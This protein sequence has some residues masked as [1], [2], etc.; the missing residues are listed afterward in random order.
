MTYAPEHEKELPDRPYRGRME[1][2]RAPRPGARGARTAEDPHHPRD[3][4][5]RLL[6]PQK[7]LPLA[8]TSARLPALA[9]RLLVVRKMARRRNPFE[10]LT[11]AL[12]ERLR[13]RLGRNPLPSAGIADSQS[14]KTTG[15]GGQQRGYDGGK[16]V[17][18]R[19]RHL[20]VDTEGLLLKARVHSAK[21]PDQDGLRLLLESA[22]SVLSRLKHL[23]L[24]AGYEGRGR[25]WA[26]EALGISVEIVR[27][28]AKPV[29]EKV[30]M[31]WA[32]ECAKEGKEVDWQRFMPPRGYVALPRRWVVERTFS[33][34]SQ[35]RRMSKDYER[36]CAS[37]EAFVYA[38]MIRL[39]V[40]RLARG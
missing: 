31:I 17:R 2:P 23:W 7:R 14:A 40:R 10:R 34:L 27:K 1:M 39:M 11:A 19:K 24:D 5:C 30:A 12:R 9:D 21:V 4:R 15:V 38:A 32:N 26:E 22:Q 3:P 20:L 29:P 37:A 35:N 25:R 28:P 6:R 33:W 8:A 36:L 16:K 18:G 13:V